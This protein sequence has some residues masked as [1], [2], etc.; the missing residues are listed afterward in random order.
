MID[1]ELYRNIRRL[2]NEGHGQRQIARILGCARKTIRKYCQGAVLHDARATKSQL[3]IPLM[4]AMEKEIGALLEENKTLPK[5][6]RRNARDIWRALKGKGFTVG[7][8][9]IRRHVRKLAEEHQAFVPLDFEP[10]ELMQVDWGDM[11]AF[12]GG[13]NTNISVFVTVL[14]Y[15]YAIY[16]SVFPDKSEMCVVEG[17]VR[18]FSFYGGVTRRCLYDNMRTAAASG[19]GVHAVKHKKLMELEA[20]YGFE[21]NFCNVA[22]GWE[23]GG[24]ENGVAVVRRL[25]FTPMPH[26]LD[27]AELQ[28]HVDGRCLEYTRTHKIRYR[29]AGIKA[30]FEEERRSLNPLPLLPMEAAKTVAALVNSDLTVLLDGTRYSVPLNYVGE[31]V[32]LKVSPFT[33]AVWARGEEV[34]RHKRAL[35][36]GD[37][38]YVPEHYLEL[39]TSKPRSIANAAPLRKGIMPKELKDFLSIC[40]A[41]DKEQQLL[42]IMLLARS[43]DPDALLLAVRQANSSGTPTYQL[44]CYYLNISLPDAG[45]ESPGITVE[46]IDLTEYDRL[47]GSEEDHD[48]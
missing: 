23:K 19:S 30:M 11:R 43:V 1:L 16:A 6:Q 42:D 31:R 22:S 9:T 20:H 39:L 2:H 35:Q 24:V 10:G 44:V 45:D 32:T 29:L 13:V 48:E 28:Q 33:V 18:A 40:R 12:I 47:V 21:G 27:H 46:H 3:E 38:Q 34:Y 41:R 36:K 4:Q 5:K 15:S 17:H 25:A 14:P 26:A 8:S 37:H 7:E